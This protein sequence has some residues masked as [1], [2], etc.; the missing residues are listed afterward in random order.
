MR[1]RGGLSD[2]PTILFSYNS[3]RAGKAPKSFLAGYSG[4]I[5][6]DGYNGY[7]FIDDE[8]KQTRISC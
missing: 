5:Q 2:K 4:Y 8:K 1:L 3:S 6:A 7:K